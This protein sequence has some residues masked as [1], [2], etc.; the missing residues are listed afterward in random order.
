M[1]KPI[2]AT[3]RLKISLLLSLL[4]VTA[5]LAQ[6]QPARGDDANAENLR[7]HV[8]A[9]ASDE[10]EGRRTGTPGAQKAAAYV[11]AEFKRLGLRTGAS[12]ARES[13]AESAARSMSAYLQL[14][15]YVAGVT[16]GE[17]NAMSFI[18]RAGR[19]PQ[20]ARAGAVDLRLGEDWTPLAWSANGRAEGKVVYVG[21]GIT[22][23]ELNHDD[24][25]GVDA[26]GKIVF[27]FAGTPDG[28]NPHGRFASF[29]DLRFKAAAAR[30]HGA[31][32]LLV[33]SREENFKDDRAARLSVDENLAAA[34]DAGLPVVLISRQVARRAVAAAAL[35]AVTFENLEQSADGKPPGAQPAAVAKDSAAQG[36]GGAA[37]EAKRGEAQG[38]A[39]GMG[40]KNAPRKNGST[41]LGNIAFSLSTDV[42]RREAPAFN[43]VGVVEGSDP[44]LKG[45]AVV[46]GAHYDHLGRGGAGSLAA[47][48]GD[49]HHGADDNASGVAGLLELARIVSDATPRA[50]RTV[51]FV[52]FGGEEEG[53][54]G[55]SYYVKNPVV[56]LAQTVAMLNMDMIGRMKDD[57]L[58]VGG[59]GTAAEWRELIGDANTDLNMRVNIKGVAQQSG[60]IPVVTSS[61]G[62]VIATANPKPRFSLT[63][64]EDGYGPSD[65]SSFYA[66]QVPVLFFWTGTHE[67]YHKPSDTADKIG[68]YSLARVTEFVRDV[69]RAVDAG[70]KRPTYAAAKTDA[71]VGRSTGFR[72]YLGTIPNYAEGG[73]GLK[74][75]G[76]R[77][78]SPAEAAGLRAGDVIVRM[79]GRDVKNVYDYTYALGEMKA[80]EE[81]EVEAVRGGE[82][83]KLKITPAARK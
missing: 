66:K 5:A 67:D 59:V 41:P 38:T 49:I 72:V 68:Y 15:P 54:I 62:T 8:R 25:A 74:L 47:R 26:R 60:D 30:E 28:D 44:K 43:V 10:F 34:G 55:S 7:A 31:V 79:A 52:A 56:P 78:G 81:Y 70:D 2:N 46:V 50:R 71:T 4:F 12:V 64:N 9:L 36:G 1:N 23:A 11:E 65:H 18:P 24:Y 75:D 3:K 22:A 21:Y 16:L 13:G 42:A 58:I 19:S 14:F 76:V 82:R 51:V 77:E 48:E 32:A 37:A 29:G 40:Q 61:N 73:E 17:D 53:L 39:Q 35:P 69:L 57:K 63:L 45:E 20:N 83:M 6:Q 33:V 27:A 80:G